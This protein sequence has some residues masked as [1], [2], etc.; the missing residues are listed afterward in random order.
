MTDHSHGH[1]DALRVSKHARK[2]MQQR[3][4]SDEDLGLLLQ[5]GTEKGDGLVLRKRDA[6]QAIAEHKRQIDRLEKLTGKVVILVG[7]TVVTT[8]APSPRRARKYRRS[9]R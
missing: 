6:A 1:T 3:S 5:Y 8:F 7:G 2:R 4:V 9:W